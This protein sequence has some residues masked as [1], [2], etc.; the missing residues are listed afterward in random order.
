MLIYKRPEFEIKGETTIQD[1]FGVP[2]MHMMTKESRG[3]KIFDISHLWK[4]W[5]SGLTIVVDSQ[6]HACL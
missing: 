5:L 3:F 6:F 4:P 1:R 2:P